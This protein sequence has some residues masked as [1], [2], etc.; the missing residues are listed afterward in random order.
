MTW[1]TNQTKLQNSEIKKIENMEMSIELYRRYWIQLRN[2]FGGTGLK[3]REDGGKV[4]CEKILSE[5]C[6]NMA[7]NINRCRFKIL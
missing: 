6:S 2:V 3:E 7:N 4:I 5:K 1:K